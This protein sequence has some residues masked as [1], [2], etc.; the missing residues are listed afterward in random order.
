[1]HELEEMMIESKPLHKKKHRIKKKR[2]SQ[3]TKDGSDSTAL[4]E[5]EE[6]MKI[7]SAKFI[8]FNREIDKEMEEHKS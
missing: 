7:Y 5:E 8:T 3:R 4:N 1:M 6:N 2:A